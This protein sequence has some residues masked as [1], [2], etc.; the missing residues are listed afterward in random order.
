MIFAY[1]ASDRL[2]VVYPGGV[3][4]SDIAADLPLL[5]YPPARPD[6]TAH[7][8]PGAQPPARPTVLVTVALLDSPHRVRRRARPRDLPRAPHRR[9][10]PGQRRLA[11]LRNASITPPRYGTE[12]YAAGADAPLSLTI[13]NTADTADVLL[14]VGTTAATTAELVDADGAALPPVVLATGPT[15]PG[16][17]SVVLRTLTAP[18]RPGQSMP[19]TFTFRDSGRETLLVPVEV[20]TQPAPVP[21]EHVFAEHEG[22]GVEG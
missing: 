17:F 10:S 7:R 4:P 16:Q 1:D 13:V 14:S 8:S 6:P 22:G 3:T 20:Y 19:V 12:E 2:P 15:T 9:R 18:M 11:A 21:T 5:A